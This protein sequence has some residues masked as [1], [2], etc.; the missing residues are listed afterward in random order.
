MSS[1]H[2]SKSNEYR[3]AWNGK[4][5]LITGGT[6]S[7]GVA[8]ASRILE[9][10]ELKRLVILSRDEWKQADLRRRISDPRVRWFLGDVR[11][12]E[13]L[14]RAFFGVD[15]VIHA[16]ALKRVD[17]AEYDPF[18]YVKT[19]IIGSQNV[20]DIAID[21]GVGHVIALS[22]DKA[23][24][25]IN[26]YGATK[27]A[28]DKLFV[29]GNSYGG[30]G[31]TKMAVV[32]YGNVLGS[33]GSVVPL[34]LDLVRQG[35]PLPI[36]DERMT[37]FWI[38]LDAA[39]T[40]V[41]ESL[42]QMRGGELFVPKL[43]SMRVVDLASAI[44]PSATLKLTGVRPGEKLHE[45]MISVDDGK[46]TFDLGDRYVVTPILNQWSND[47]PRGEPVGENFSYCSDTNSEW[48]NVG[49]L[50]RILGLE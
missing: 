14:K 6:G 11:D 12:R 50:R 25:P 27:L 36:T 21:S 40:F 34:F 9:E 32:R 49:D 46:N 45:E 4:S 31:G 2:A 18:E 24:S 23:S 41:F 22:T 28:A 44:S 30:G 1:E 33:R 29:A 17:T 10:C 26:L 37:R 20:I 5:V 42:T 43:P 7:F 15:V 39:V 19:N 3:E 38:S 16:A 13:R 35:A 47:S 48:L 8:F